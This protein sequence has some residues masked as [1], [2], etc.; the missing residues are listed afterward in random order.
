[1]ISQLPKWVETGAFVL[2]LIAGVVNAV[3]LLGFEHQSVSHLSGIATLLGTSLITD[4][5][6]NVLHISGLML[7]FLMGSAISGFMLHGVALKLGRHYDTL[8][9]LE[10]VLLTM[11][12][13]LLS[14]EFFYGHY[15]ASAACGLQNAMATTYSGAIIRTT[16]VTGIFTDLGI[17]IGAFLR[18]EELDIRKLKLFTLIIAGFI[19]GGVIG[20]LLYSEYYFMTLLFPAAVCMVIALIYRIYTRTHK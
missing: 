16:H 6:R 11:A 5:L 7:A 20:V 8:L 10:A 2:A 17:M 3:G 19:S 14:K 15:L 1:M 9:I 18:G 12:F 4:S 13:L